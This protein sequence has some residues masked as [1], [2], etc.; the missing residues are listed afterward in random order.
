MHLLVQN[1][2]VFLERS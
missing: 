2:I 1:M